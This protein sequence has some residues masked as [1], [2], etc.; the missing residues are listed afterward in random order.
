M[1]G[2]Q[3][4][5]VDFGVP[6]RDGRRSYRWRFQAVL[7][8]STFL[9]ALSQCG[10]KELPPINDYPHF[11]EVSTERI[12]DRMLY[13]YQ[14]IYRTLSPQLQRRITPEGCRRAALKNLEVKLAYHTPLMKTLSAQCYE[15]ILEAPCKTIAAVAVWNPSCLLLRRE[16]E[17]VLKNK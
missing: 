2:M 10:K 4:L 15:A 13:C 11:L 3:H 9:L 17:N 16:T 5:R 14:K 12:C 6:E 7:F 1:A 8:I